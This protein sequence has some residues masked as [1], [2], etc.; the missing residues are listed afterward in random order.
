M[1][2][3]TIV[4]LGLF[5]ALAGCGNGG[6]AADG[7]DDGRQDADGSGGGDVSFECTQGVTQCPAGLDCLCCGSIGP[8]AICLC[9]V[10]CT[11]GAD[12]TTQGLPECN[13]PG[14]GTAGICTP[15]GFN[16]CWMCQ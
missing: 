9:S 7:G 16:C 13:Q 8:A 2:R 5:L 4:A 14:A 15:A 3:A 11:S 10:E 6:G 1:M 12:C